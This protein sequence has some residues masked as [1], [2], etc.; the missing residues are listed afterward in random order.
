MCENAT[1]DRQPLNPTGGNILIVGKSGQLSTSLGKSGLERLIRIGRPVI[2]FDQPETLNR[3]FAAVQPTAVVNAAAWTAV[4][5]AEKEPEAATR[6]N[7]DGP[8]YLAMLCARSKIPFIHVSTDYVFD[9]EKKA[10]YV[11]SD[12]VSPRSVYGRT[13]AEGE[14]AVIAANPSSIILRT[15]WV[16]SAFSEN[17]VRTMLQI[18]A[19]AP[20]LRVV[21]DQKGSPTSADDLAQVILSILA[22]LERTDRKDVY[23]GVYH[24]CGGGAATWYELATHVLQEATQYGRPMPEVIPITTQDW[25]TTAIRPADTRLN[26]NKL[27]Q[28]FDITL[29][30]WKKSASRVVHEICHLEK[31]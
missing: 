17:F 24:A 10:P 19:H 26:T 11:E 30:D 6:A 8:Q 25:P 15:S 2:D 4:D 7:R 9:G 16:Y 1:G 18:G 29:P 21:A 22:T 5:M 31:R 13:K 28:V 14:K 23:A 3:A 12:L 20:C 27:R